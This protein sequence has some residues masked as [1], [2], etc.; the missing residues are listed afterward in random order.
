MTITARTKT[1]LRKKVQEWAAD[2][3]AVGLV[4]IRA[5]YEPRR[6]KK[7]RSGYSIEVWAHS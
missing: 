2:R 7:T 3:R 6:V 5:G 4:D 1:A